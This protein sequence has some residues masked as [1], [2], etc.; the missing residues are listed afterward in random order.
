VLIDLSSSTNRALYPQTLFVGR[1]F[2]SQTA[3]LTGRAGLSAVSSSQLV[4]PLIIIY[5]LAREILYF[6]T[7]ADTQ[8][9]RRDKPRGFGVDLLCIRQQRRT[10]QGDVATVRAR[11][12]KIFADTPLPPQPKK[13]PNTLTCPT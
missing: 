7:E 8:N 12:Y 9:C 3:L 4:R 13:N 5:R 11:L 2:I 10:R 6:Q 1:T